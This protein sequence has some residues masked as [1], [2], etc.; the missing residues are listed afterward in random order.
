MCLW[1]TMTSVVD[2]KIRFTVTII[3]SFWYYV[4]IHNLFNNWIWFKFWWNVLTLTIVVAIINSKNQPWTFKI[5]FLQHIFDKTMCY[6][7]FWVVWNRLICIFATF[8]T[9]AL[10]DIWLWFVSTT[11]FLIINHFLFLLLDWCPNFRRGKAQEE[12]A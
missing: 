12:D 1:V 4:T 9:V 2:I 11:R 5:V 10:R 8:I 6:W 7:R 3:I